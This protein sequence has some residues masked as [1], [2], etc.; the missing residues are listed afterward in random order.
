MENY[1]QLQRTLGLSR[2]VVVQPSAYGFDNR[3]TLAAIATLGNRGRGV[4]VVD[5]S[6]ADAELERLTAHGIRGL[7]FFMLPGGALGWEALPKLAARVQE[8]GWHIQLQMD[9]RFMAERL[10]DLQQLPC[11]LVID[12]N[13][14]FLEPVGLEHPGFLALRDLIEWGRTWVKTSGVYETSHVGPPGYDDVA[15]LARQLIAAYPERC[16][17][18]TNWP[19][20]SKPRD[21]PDDA[22]LIDLFAGWCGNAT[23]MERIMVGNPQDVYGFGGNDD[24]LG[25]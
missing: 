21:P 17:W 5:E 1:L 16:L 13:G 15:I 4:A 11:S 25:A 7:R 24:E 14:K 18:A 23:T 22:V 10:P 6:V 12:H 9:G 2:A 8:F 20:P 3:C 19:H